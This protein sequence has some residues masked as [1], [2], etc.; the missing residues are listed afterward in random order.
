MPLPHHPLVSR[1]TSSVALALA[2][3]GPATASAQAEPGRF[4]LGLEVKEVDGVLLVQRV[5]AGSAAARARLEVGERIVALEGVPVGSLRQLE[6]ELA[7]RRPGERLRLD[8]RP[9]I[10]RFRFGALATGGLFT[11]QD[12]TLFGF[13][14]GQFSQLAFGEAT[15]WVLTAGYSAVGRRPGFGRNVLSG[16]LGF[17]GAWPIFDPVALITRALFTLNAPVGTGAIPGGWTVEPVGMQLHLGLR[18]SL[19]EL[20]ACGGLGPAEGLNLGVGVA[21]AIGFGGVSLED[22][23]PTAVY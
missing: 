13:V 18:W 2:L 17:E 11:G 20:F 14:G 22:P 19:F 21:A 5:S 8:L 7:R 6:L 12:D 23:G 16:G 3:F 9:V 4:G 1:P 10:P 15:A